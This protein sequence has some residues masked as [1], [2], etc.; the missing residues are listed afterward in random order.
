MLDTLRR[1]LGNVGLYIALQ[2]VVG[3]DRV[4]YRCLDEAELKPGERVLDVGCG[5][6]YYLDRLPDVEYHGFDTSPT[7]IAYARRRFGDRGEFHCEMLT[8]DGLAD[9]P[10]F[11]A[12]LLLGLLHHLDDEDSAVLLDLAS[13]ALA[14][15]GRVV[16][17]DPCLHVGQGRISRWMTEN[18][19]GEHP[20][21]PEAFDALARASFGEVRSEILDT[22]SRVP[23]SHYMMVLTAPRRAGAQRSERASHEDRFRA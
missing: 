18:D 14:D 4:R 6:A 20:R 19:R 23:T 1:T 17:A 2:R 16:T 12:V 8:E 10:R 21:T 13:R 7:Y 5:P 15:G 11:D 22:V 3:A 9:L